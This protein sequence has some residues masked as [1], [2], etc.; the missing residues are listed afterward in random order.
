MLVIV[1]QNG[2]P[3]FARFVVSKLQ[4]L[5]I[6]LQ[7]STTSNATG[8]KLVWMFFFLK[9]VIANQWKASIATHLETNFYLLLWSR[10]ATC[11]T[12]TSR[13]AKC[14]GTTWIPPAHKTASTTRPPTALSS[15]VTANLTRSWSHA[16]LM[17]PQFF[18][19]LP[20]F[21]Q[22]SGKKAKDKRACVLLPCVSIFLLL[23]S[24]VGTPITPQNSS[25]SSFCLAT[26][27]LPAP[28]ESTETSARHLHMDCTTAEPSTA[29]VTC[30]RPSCRLNSRC[31]E[32]TDRGRH[33]APGAR[34]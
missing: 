20:T 8:T 28:S 4:Q 29:E 16:S 34:G 30:S 15:S 23:C 19:K 18:W 25:S 9:H 1:K 11:V 27:E 32:T 12:L 31:P 22:V 2:T 17:T 26:C 7:I 33:P 10:L 24:F 13:Q 21:G 5:F 6:L 3:W 14:G